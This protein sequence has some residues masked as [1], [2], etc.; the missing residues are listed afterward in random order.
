MKTNKLYKYINLLF[1]I[2]IGAFAIWFIYIKLKDYS[3]SVWDVKFILKFK[4]EYLLLATLLLF[5][6]WGI[7]AKK[8]KYLIRETIKIKWYTAFKK[9]MT[10]ITVGLVTPNRIGEIPARAILLNDKKN[11][12]DLIVKTSVGAYS[13]LLVTLFFGTMASLFSLCVFQIYAT[14]YLNV[15]LV[16]ITIVM[17]SSYFFQKYVVNIFY[18]IGYVKRKNLLDGLNDYGIVQLT[19]VFFLSSLRY[20]VFS[21][22]FYLV[23][24]AFN[25][26]FFSFTELLLIPLCFMITSFIPTILISEIGVRGSVALFVFGTISNMEAQ[27]V[28]ASVI[29]WFINIAFPALMGLINIS[30]FKILEEN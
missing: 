30:D 8:W 24:S 29:L 26:Q 9:I 7:E 17:A 22:Q 11:L 23:L 25:F 20:L 18:K 10:S 3:F 28:L 4:Y 16:I 6:N 21:L 1:R 14:V 13:Q 12:K 15:C 2:L 5:L 27:I 19:F